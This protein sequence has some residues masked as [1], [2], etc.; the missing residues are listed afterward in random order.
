MN[1]IHYG[2]DETKTSEL[3]ALQTQGYEMGRVLI[4]HKHTYR[5]ATESGEI[6][7][8]LSGKFR[9]EIEAREQ[10]PAVGDWVAL[11]I[12]ETEAKGVI[13]F[14]LP[15]TSQFTRKT[16]GS[17][18]EMQVVAAN[19]D[20][21]FLVLALN[22]DFNL[23]RLERYL[24]ITWES[25]ATPVVILNKSD[26]CSDIEQKKSEVESVALGV[27]IHF[28]SA[29]DHTGLSEL[30]AYLKPGATV[31]LL[32]SSGVGKS[33]LTNAL[34]ERDHQQTQAIRE[35]DG[36]GKH[37]TTH[38]ELI[39]LPQGSCLIDTPGMREL[40]LWDGSSGIQETF[41]DIERLASNC[42][43]TDCRHVQEPGCAIQTAIAENTLQPERLASYLKLQRELAYLAR[44]ENKQLQ[45]RERETWK[46]RTKTYRNQ[47]KHR[48]R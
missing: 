47:M 22:Q 48:K 9:Y 17:R 30:S 26:L 38:R 25:G 1:L 3:Q 7:A 40:Q 10:Y 27:P 19:V 34:L 18:H 28:V 41:E 5:V 37:T 33:T 12:Q 4:E 6:L 46:K 36:K 21:I 45:S 2:F 11:S 29:A 44:R 31:A 32:G 14:V 8:H 16:P 23:K 39:P 15:R 35:Q 24:V 13:Q 20:T 43:F 42:Q